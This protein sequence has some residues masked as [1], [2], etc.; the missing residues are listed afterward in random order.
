MNEVQQKACD[1]YVAALKKAHGERKIGDKI[2]ALIT[3]F[4]ANHPE[5]MQWGL[6][7]LIAI[8]TGGTIP[9]PVI[10]PTPAV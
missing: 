6:A 3:T 4:F 1:E 10:T 5:L 7:A 8:L 2:V 9:V